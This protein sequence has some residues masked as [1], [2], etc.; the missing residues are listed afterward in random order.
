YVWPMLLF[1]LLLWLSA[2]LAQRLVGPEG[3]L[4]AL[5]LPVLS[6]AITAE[7]TPGR[8]DHHNVVILLT[9]AMIWAGIEAI[10]CPRFAIACGV[11]AATALAIATESL[12]T[13]AAAILVMGLAFVVDP[14]RGRTM[15]LFGLSFA[16]GSMV[17][18]AIFRPPSRW[19]EAAC[20]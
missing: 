20:D 1:A 7:F 4:P 16:L 12:P 10:R 18:L 17:H 11:L 14:A 15:R 13:I 6:P 3:V 5:V 19:L 8:V 2:G 9:L